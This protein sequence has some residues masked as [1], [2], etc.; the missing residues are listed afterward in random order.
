MISCGSKKRLFLGID[1]SCYTTSAA[2]VCVSGDST[3]IVCDERILLK[4][5]M[6]E[7]G[8]RQSD[9]VFQHVRNLT[10]I[11]PK[12]FNQIDRKAVAGI[13][14]SVC[15]SGREGS[16]MPVF[17]AG[18]S[19][20]LSVSAALGVPVYEFTHQQG[21]IRA[22]AFGNESLLGKDFFAF[23]L[24]GGTNELLRIDSSLSEI[25]KIGGTTDINAGQLV[26]RLGVAMGLQFPAGKELERIAADALKNESNDDYRFVLPS[27]V[28]NLSCSFSGVE[29]KAANA[30][31]GGAEHGT[32]AAA[33]YDCI[34][35]TLAKL[36]KNAIEI[37]TENAAMRDAYAASK[38]SKGN[39]TASTSNFLFA[40]GVAS[41]TI[42]R[43]MLDDRLKKTPAE[44]HFSRPVLS[45]DNAVG[46][47]ALAADE[48]AFNGRTATLS[49]T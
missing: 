15:P 9:A 39:E 49:G 5:A 24:S 46:I 40:G 21:H 1:T 20:A 23:H 48:G 19:H 22:A 27:S 26:D 29:T 42:L 44:L 28:K 4:V 35:R 6:G 25:K 8:L 37:E 17:L 31:K 3:Q 10:E 43:K 32:V 13:G 34:A 38:Y 12:V 33:V 30:L 11:L 45:S 7:R 18:K 2:C 47:A 14:V 36:V 41:S 16:Y